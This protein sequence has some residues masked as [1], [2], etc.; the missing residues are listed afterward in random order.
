MTKTKGKWQ[1]KHSMVLLRILI[2]WH[3]LYEGVIKLYNP[4]WTSFGYLATAQGPFK[5]IFLAIAKEPMIG[6]AD[7]L[8]WMA[9]MFVGITFLLGMFEKKGALVAIFLLALYYLAHPPF[10]W[11]MQVNVE[12]S[13]W[14]VN[15]NLIEL[16]AC[17][18]I[19]QFPTGQYFGLP[20]LFNK[21]KEQT[22]T[23]TL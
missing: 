15:K 3:F 20:Y 17:M 12:G 18:V 7:T 23:E 6:W 4:D 9:L 14:F 13:Y 21:N 16:A 19:Y 8:N 11:L 22:K 1:L 5:P 10:P 2:G